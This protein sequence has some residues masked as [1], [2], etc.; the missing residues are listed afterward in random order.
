MSLQIRNVYFVSTMASPPLKGRGTYMQGVE[1][2]REI[3]F[4]LERRGGIVRIGKRD[5]FK[6]VH[7]LE[8]LESLE[9][10]ET[11]RFPRAWTTKENPEEDNEPFQHGGFGPTLDP[12]IPPPPQFLCASFLVED[13]KY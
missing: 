8:I 6:N 4:K 9:V 2:V 5:L 12:S 3:M 10:K 13:G 7:F 11:L 1:G